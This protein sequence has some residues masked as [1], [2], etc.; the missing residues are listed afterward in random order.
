MSDLFS[1]MAAERARVLV[2]R[3]KP[4]GWK[5]NDAALNAL[6]FEGVIDNA[7]LQPPIQKALFGLPVLRDDDDQ[8]E[9]ARFSILVVK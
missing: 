5:L 7:D 2:E 6:R 9:E 3:K 4:I 8:S 1:R